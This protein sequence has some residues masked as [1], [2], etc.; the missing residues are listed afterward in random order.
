MGLILSLKECIKTARNITEEQKDAAKR[1]RSIK[2]K[3][4]AKRSVEFWS[5][6][7]YHLERL[8]NLDKGVII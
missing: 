2:S 4:V 5:A 3:N 6:I 1:A 8:E 7:A